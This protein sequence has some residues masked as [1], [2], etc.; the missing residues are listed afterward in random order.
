MNPV[1]TIQLLNLSFYAYHGI[2]EEE[3][4]RGGE[5]EVNVTVSHQPKINPVLHINETIDYVSVYQLLKKHMM[6]PRLLLETV[7]TTFANDLFAQFAEAEELSI[8]IIK[9]HPPI[10]AFEGSV[11]VSYTAKREK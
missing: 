10:A 5:F 6:Q 9:K 1:L 2:H 3:K 4:K 7:A 8:T 11:G